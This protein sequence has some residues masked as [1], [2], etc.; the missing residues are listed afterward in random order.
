MFASF[1]FCMAQSSTGYLYVLF[2]DK[3]SVNREMASWPES[4]IMLTQNLGGFLVTALQTRIP[5]YYVAVLSASL[6]GIGLLGAAF[7]PNIQW[8]SGAFG[9][10][11]GTGCGA[12][13]IS[14]TVYTMLYFDKYRAT[15]TAFKYIGWAASG[16][17]GPLVFSALAE[18]YG[19]GGALLI[20]AGITI[21][22][23]PI[24]MSLKHPKP[25]RL[26]FAERCFQKQAAVN[27]QHRV[28]HDGSDVKTHKTQE[29]LEAPKTTGHFTSECRAKAQVRT[30]K[31]SATETYLDAKS[32]SYAECKNETFSGQ[33]PPLAEKRS[34]C[35]SV[36]IGEFQV[37]C[38]KNKK[39]I[40][41]LATSTAPYVHGACRQPQSIEV[42]TLRQL[43]I[44]C[45]L[46]FYV[47]LVVYALCD[48]SIS[49]H[50]TTVVDYCMD[51]GSALDKAK[52]VL[53]YNAAGQFAGRTLL[54]FGSDNVAHSRCPLAVACF[55]CAGALL[56]AIS[57]VESFPA[58]VGLNMV[59]GVSQ[60]FVTCIRSVLV[61][62][63][64][65]V[66]RLPTFFGILGLALVPLSFSGPSVIGFFRD[67]LGSYDN[68]YRMLGG[69]NLCIAAFL[70]VLVWRDKRRRKVWTC[71]Q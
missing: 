18:H 53:T 56:L 8:V 62:D 47:L 66:D 3:F 6:C 24:A 7:S 20:G 69:V 10:I 41:G 34:L 17:A 29:E 16:L 27:V 63:Y 65:G 21:H 32:L 2:M 4:I 26:K 23:V 40:D 37:M 5:V 67:T 15:A 51:K 22:A 59:V 50:T 36:S 30:R 19:L 49:M 39:N 60:G 45:E 46:S 58:F 44:L 38:S 55:A 13:I 14:Y 68:F 28:E 1:L 48:C 61:N 11:Y 31:F 54:P 43:S 52:L 71:Q 25:L 42:H 9:G 12:S 64:L 57:A 33:L 70:F 35:T